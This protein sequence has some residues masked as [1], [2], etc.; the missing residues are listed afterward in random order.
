MPLDPGFPY[1]ETSGGEAFKR[2]G[3][4]AYLAAWSFD[5]GWRSETGEEAKNFSSAEEAEKFVAYLLE[6]LSLT[7]TATIPC[8]IATGQNVRNK[9]EMLSDK[10]PEAIEAPIDSWLTAAELAI[11]L[12][13]LNTWKVDQQQSPHP[14]ALWEWKENENR[15]IL[16]FYAIR[17]NRFIVKASMTFDDYTCLLTSEAQETLHFALKDKHWGQ[18]RD[19]DLRTVGWSPPGALLKEQRG[20]QKKRRKTEDTPMRYTIVINDD[21]DDELI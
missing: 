1:V 7:A 10:I 18:I 9:L 14:F 2:N 11:L 8:N 6:N 20:R 12:H 15:F 17:A 19:C 13:Q 3:L 16:S 5:N 21:D 4:C